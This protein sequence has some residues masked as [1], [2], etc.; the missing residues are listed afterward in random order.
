[1]RSRDS[2]FS[3]QFHLVPIRITHFWY[4]KAYDTDK[5]KET[6]TAP[7]GGE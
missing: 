7:G 1:V 6:A 3:V 4:A 2:R 5:S